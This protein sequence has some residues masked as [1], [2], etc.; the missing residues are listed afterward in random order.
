[1]PANDEEFKQSLKDLKLLTLFNTSTNEEQLVA[2]FDANSMFM[3]DDL[4]VDAFPS[5]TSYHFKFK[6]FVGII[7]APELRLNFYPLVD[8]LSSS[9][10]FPFA[11]PPGWHMS[12]DA[13]Y[14]RQGMPKALLVN[15]MI[16][17]V[18]AHEEYVFLSHSSGV[19]E[20]LYDSAF[21]RYNGDC[22]LY[23]S[24]SPRDKRQSRMPSSA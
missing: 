6:N 20:E 5:I 18:D 19:N 23:T 8:S 16:R 15:S 13:D 24:P 7:N 12:S 9:F 14:I 1:M 4:N 3:S 17:A 22:L 21:V 10:S 2:G 11:K